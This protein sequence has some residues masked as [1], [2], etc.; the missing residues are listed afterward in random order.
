MHK[1]QLRPPACR[2]LRATVPTGGGGP[3]KLRTS[4]PCPLSHCRHAVR[5]N[6]ENRVVIGM[7]L[8]TATSAVESRFETF[9]YAAVRENPDGA[10]LTVLSI[11]ARLNI[12]PWEEAARLAHLPRE[13][14]VRALAGLISALPKGSTTPTDSGTI[15]ARLITLLPRPSQ[16]R[17]A[18]QRVS[19]GGPRSIRVPKRAIVV[20]RA[21][22][23]LIAVALLFVSQWVAVSYLVSLPAKK[24]PAVPAMVVPAQATRPDAPP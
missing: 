7:A 1:W 4:R 14:A 8:A 24:P 19:S 22:L 5:T 20:A 16:G 23:F 17:T 10:P 6:S 13:A 2:H 15:A 11:L 9:L 12:D 3:V 21:I 18:A